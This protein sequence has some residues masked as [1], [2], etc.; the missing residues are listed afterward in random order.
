MKCR[1]MSAATVVLALATAACGGNEPAP[2]AGDTAGVAASDA[3]ESTPAEQAEVVAAAAAR[4]A[5]YAQC[6]S[7]H[8]TEQGAASTIGPNLFGVVGRAAGTVEGFNYSQPMKNSGVTWNAEQLDAY[9][10]TP[11]KVVPGTRMAFG[12][13]SDATK[14]KEI[15][16][17]LTSLK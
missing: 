3:T 9:I 11:Q 1:L 17:Y 4:P 12:G 10:T 14:R 13:V 2:D 15:V 5:S 16:D 7:C 6:A 8:A